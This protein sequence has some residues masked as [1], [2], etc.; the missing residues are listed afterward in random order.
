MS[1][2]QQRSWVGWTRREHAHSAERQWKF[3]RVGTDDTATFA[4]PWTFGSGVTA[5][6]RVGGFTFNLIAS[7]IVFQGGGFLF[8]S[9]TGTITGNGFAAT[10]AL[11]SLAFRMTQ[12]AACFPGLAGVR[13]SPTAVL[14]LLCWD[15]HWRES[16]AS[17]ENL[18]GQRAEM[19]FQH[20]KLGRFPRSL[21]A[22]L[23]TL[24]SMSL[25][26]SLHSAFPWLAVAWRRRQFSALF[27]HSPHNS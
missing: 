12:Q 8:V 22:T 13:L 18:G 20:L 4:F 21:I 23:A 5:L 11:G 10:M 16:K 17:A 15:W 2:R 1:I 3:R 9:G 24:P 14:R 7:H 19:A 25:L 26:P 27:S 6:W